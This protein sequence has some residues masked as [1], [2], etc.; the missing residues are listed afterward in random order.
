MG[1]LSSKNDSRPLFLAWLV[2]LYT[3]SSALFAFLSLANV[4]ERDYRM[5]FFWL[6]VA[7]FVD[8]TDGV[9]A[10]AAQ[11]RSRLPWFNGAKLDDIVDYLTY[12]FVPAVMVWDASLVPPLLAVPIAAAMLFASAYGFNREDAKTE[13]HFFTGFPS[14]WN[15]VV[16]YLY[17]AG[18]HPAVNAAILILLVVLV[19]VPIRY[20]YPSRTPIFR[21]LTIL[22]GALWGAVM[23]AMLWRL[24]AAPGILLWL[25]LVFP[26]YYLL[27]SLALDA[28]RLRSH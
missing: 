12:V 22:L 9:L 26:V 13:D 24:P 8:S 10:R 15:I 25:S 28:R 23:I 5:A 14:Y 27:L 21:G 3:A 6:F 19:F 17:L 1:Q 20:V 7:V 2:H 11:V 4:F 16:F 18:V